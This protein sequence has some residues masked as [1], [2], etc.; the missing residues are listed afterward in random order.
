MQEFAQQVGVF[1]EMFQW[2]LLKHSVRKCSFKTNQSFVFSFWDRLVI[3]WRTK[4]HVFACSYSGSDWPIIKLH[5]FEWQ[6][7]ITLLNMHNATNWRCCYSYSVS[8]WFKLIWNTLKPITGSF[9]LLRF[10]KVIVI[11]LTF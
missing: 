11:I 7:S 10:A 4:I 3:R 1:R 8:N 5:S 6:M 2:V 9:R